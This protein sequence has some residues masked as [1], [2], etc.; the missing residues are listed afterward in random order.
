MH[1]PTPALLQGGKLDD[2]TLVMAMVDEEET[3]VVRAPLQN[4]EE[5]AAE[6][7]VSDSE[8]APSAAA[9]V[10]AVLSEISAD[11]RGQDDDAPRQPVTAAQA[12]GRTAQQQ[13]AA[14]VWQAA[15]QLAIC[16]A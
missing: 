16:A 3:R 2:I 6:V 9:A 11:L 14:E 1:P 8:A 5:D 15:V 10:A 12:G 13:P 4:A 7:L